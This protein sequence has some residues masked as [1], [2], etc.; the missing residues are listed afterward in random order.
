MAD[1]VGMTTSRHG[2]PPSYDETALSPLHT[3][4][5][6]ETR[7]SHLI[8]RANMRQLWVLFLAG[9]AVQLPLIVPVDGVPT[10]PDSEQTGYL[11]AKVRDTMDDVG[12]VSVV[13]VWE[14]YGASELTAQDAAWVRALASACLDTRVPLRAMLLSHRT[15]VRWIAPDDYVFAQAA[16]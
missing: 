11:M 1:H 13:L 7:V 14:R 15:G 2:N 10:E 9:D 4:A 12:A 5:E 6:I 16:S 3:D 8:G